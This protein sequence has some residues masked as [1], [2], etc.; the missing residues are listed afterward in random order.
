MNKEDKTFSSMTRIIAFVVGL[1]ITSYMFMFS[2][3]FTEFSHTFSIFGFAATTWITVA[4][5][6][7]ISVLGG[8]LIKIGITGKT[9]F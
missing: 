2:F 9:G 5:L 1:V 3:T 8:W 7:L 6:A 4:G